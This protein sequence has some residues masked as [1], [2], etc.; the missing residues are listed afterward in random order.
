MEE[1]VNGLALYDLENL[2]TKKAFDLSESF[3]RL[4]GKEPDTVYYF[5][6]HAPDKDGETVSAKDCSLEELK[7]KAEEG[8]VSNFRMSYSSSERLWDIGLAFSAKESEFGEGMNYLEIQ[9]LNQLLDLEAQAL[10]N[11]LLDLAKGTRI[12]YGI[13][14]QLWGSTA[15]ALAYALS[16]DSSRIY[17]YENS[18]EWLYQLPSRTDELPQYHR[19]L[20]MVYR[21]NLL[22]RNHLNLEIDG[23]VLKDWIAARPENGHLEK[24]SD[25]NSLWY[26]AETELE[27]VNQALG[28]AGHLISY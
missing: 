17:D 11:L 25:N 27:R 14:Y 22:N 26:L 5:Y 23:L 10:K 2:T 1:L 12:S 9:F 18:S 6:S 21:L 20:R 8:M 3:F 7:I 13:G 16:L 28:E 15:D 19:Q 4:I 24:L